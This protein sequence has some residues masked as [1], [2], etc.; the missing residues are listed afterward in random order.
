MCVSL[1]SRCDKQIFKIHRAVAETFIPY[2]E[3]SDFILTDRKSLSNIF[4][5]KRSIKSDDSY[6]GFLLTDR[7]VNKKGDKFRCINPS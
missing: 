4:R 3:G 1:G 5:V 7:Q 6:I 2:E